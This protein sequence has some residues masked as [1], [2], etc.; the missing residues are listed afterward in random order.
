MNFYLWILILTTLISVLAF[1]SSNLMS[2]M[3]FRPYQIYEHGEWYRFF[4]YGLVHA[5]L[6]HLLVNMW[7]LYIFGSVVETSLVQL[8]GFRGE[9]FFL[10]LYVGGLVFSPLLSF[11]KHKKDIFYSAVGA[12]GAI[13]AVVF[14]FI[15]M[16]PL[17]PLMIFPIPIQIPAVFFG[18][19][20]VIYSWYMSRKAN[21]QIGHDA[22]LLGAIYG[23]V[24][25]FIIE[26]RLILHFF[27]KIF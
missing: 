18:I 1:S 24:F 11:Q 6:I 21:D 12:S 27:S 7:V 10:M 23:I 4:T 13:S 2:K 15:I 3:M 25:M 17:A 16:Y 5:D 8:K 19:A 20:Y 22:H 26:P 14:A 9:M